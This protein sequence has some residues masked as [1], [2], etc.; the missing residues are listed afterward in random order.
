VNILKDNKSHFSYFYLLIDLLVAGLSL[1]FAWIII[2]KFNLFYVYPETLL[3]S[4]ALISLFMILIHTFFFGEAKSSISIIKANFIGL[5]FTCSLIFLFGQ[6]I[7]I[8]SLLPRSLFV[9]YFAI[10]SLFE[11]TIRKWHHIQS[12]DQ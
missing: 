1:L 4:S 2:L 3:K 8:L 10:N 9:F 5:L 11:F 6:S 7:Y 12:K